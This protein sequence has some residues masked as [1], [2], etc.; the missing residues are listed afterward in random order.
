VLVEREWMFEQRQLWELE[1]YNAFNENRIPA[2]FIKKQ[3]N[4]INNNLMRKTSF[5][6]NSVSVSPLRELS[7][8]NVQEKDIKKKEKKKFKDYFKN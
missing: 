5:V 7:Q 2:K 8:D 3:P 6:N 1:R 4:L